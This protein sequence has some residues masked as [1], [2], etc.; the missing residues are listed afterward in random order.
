MG[1][2]KNWKTT[3]AGVALVSFSVYQL[4][5]FL[6]GEGDTASLKEAI[7]QLYEFLVAAGIVGGFGLIAAE[8]AK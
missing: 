1:I 7:R 3:L 8:D 4:A 6:S 5:R 2:L